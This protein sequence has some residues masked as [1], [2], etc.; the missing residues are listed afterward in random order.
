MGC[1]PGNVKSHIR[2]GR[3]ADNAPMVALSLVNNGR[4]GLNRIKSSASC[5]YSNTYISVKNDKTSKVKNYSIIYV[6]IVH[7]VPAL[8]VSSETLVVERA[9]VIPGF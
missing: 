3:S 7:Y 8:V 6:H 4:T 9:Q 2:F 5:R 1:V